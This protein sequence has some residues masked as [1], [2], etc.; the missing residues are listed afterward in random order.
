VDVA[1]GFRRAEVRE[2]E[3]VVVGYLRWLRWLLRGWVGGWRD[4]AEEAVDQRPGGLAGGG[5]EVRF[6]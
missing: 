6:D 2:V 4:G 1:V 3:E 5:R